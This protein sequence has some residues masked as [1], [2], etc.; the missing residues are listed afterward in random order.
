MTRSDILNIIYSSESFQR[1][2][3]DTRHTSDTNLY[4]F[5]VVDTEGFQ[6]INGEK[7]DVPRWYEPMAL[8]DLFAE[9]I[10][11]SDSWY[12]DWLAHFEFKGFTVE[13]LWLS[14]I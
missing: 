10:Q 1:E 9:L 8:E 13:F 5:Y 6:Y 7:I 14:E 2:D 4:Q 3:V 11:R 12:F